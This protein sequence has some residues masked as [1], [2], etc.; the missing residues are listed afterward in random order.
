MGDKMRAIKFRA[1]DNK[2]NGWTDKLAEL[3]GDKGV[4]ELYEHDEWWMKAV[5]RYGFCDHNDPGRLTWEQFTGVYDFNR[6]EIYEGDIVEYSIFKYDG[7]EVVCWGVIDYICHGFFLKPF[8][9]SG[10]TCGAIPHGCV[11]IGNIHE[12]KELI[13]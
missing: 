6:R 12:N 11:V 1:W 7:C 9:P 4:D 13:K 2:L 5:Y 10:Y 3:I 8:E